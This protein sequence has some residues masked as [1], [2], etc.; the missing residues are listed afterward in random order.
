MIIEYHKADAKII[1]ADRGIHTALALILTILILTA[2][3]QAA[4]EDTANRPYTKDRI[5]FQAIGG[6]MFAPCG[7]GPDSDVFNYSQYNLRIG[8]LLNSPSPSGGFWA[9]SWELLGELSSSLVFEGAGNYLVGPSIGL[10]YNFIQPGS[11]LIPYFMIAG[12]IVYNDAYKDQDQHDI[13]NNVEFNPKASIG[14]QYMLG[15]QWALSVEGMY[16]HISNADM[17]DRNRGINS[18]GGYLGVSYFF[19][20]LWK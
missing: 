6:A 20:G 7:I 9:G 15:S 14:L 16:Q 4:E 2:T 3:G 8:W 12:G 13:G 1:K 11:R 10:R 5:I 17:N 19:D 18:L